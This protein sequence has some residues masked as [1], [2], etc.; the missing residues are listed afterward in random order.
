[1][2]TESVATTFN[3]PL[4]RKAIAYLKEHEGRRFNMARF[5]SRSPYDFLDDKPPCGT[6]VC[7]AGAVVVVHDGFPS[8][9]MPRGY[10]DSIESR[11]A[12]LLGIEH[13]RHNHRKLFFTANWPEK[14]RD[15]YITATT[16]LDRVAALE[17]R[18]EHFVTTGE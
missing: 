13:F 6:V 12:K 10:Y 17:A 16:G 18:V 2:S 11:A 7:F 3:L 1:M 4:A 15:A 9:P 8:V 14:F 5:I